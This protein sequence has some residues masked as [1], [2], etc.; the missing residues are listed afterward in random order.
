MQIDDARKTTL[1]G[2]GKKIL[3]GNPEIIKHKKYNEVIGKC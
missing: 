1:K 2:M 3:L